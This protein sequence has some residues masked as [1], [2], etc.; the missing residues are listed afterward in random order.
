MKYSISVTER[1][2]IEGCLD[3]LLDETSSKRPVLGRFDLVAEGPETVLVAEQGNEVRSQRH[4]LA[5]FDLPA[6]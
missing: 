1:E 3:V 5:V 4:P 2:V 6:A